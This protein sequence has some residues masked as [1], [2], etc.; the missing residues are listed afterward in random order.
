[1]NNVHILPPEVI[2]KI[3]AGEVIERP[4]AAVKELIENA[5]DAETNQIELHLKQAG[6]TSIRLK[7][8]GT[9]IELDD[10]ENI[11]LRHATSK[12]SKIDDLFAINSL[13]FRGEALYSIATISDV[14]L[15]SKTKHSD[16]GW[17]IHLREGKKLNL[18]PVNMTAGTEIEINEL[19]FNTPAR[20]K[21]L[22]ST[23]VELTQILTTFIP[24]AILYP[25]YKFLLTHN[26]R[27][28]LDLSPAENFI[29]RIC[30]ALNLQ[31][32]HLIETQENIPEKNISIRLVLGD[33]NIQ[34]TRKDMQFIF[35]NNRPVHCYNLSFQI[36]QAYRVILPPQVYPF[37][38][39]YITIPA[40]NVDVNVHPAKREVKIKDDYSLSSFLRAQ[41]EKTLLASSGTKQIKE[42]T[43]NYAAPETFPA[44]YKTDDLTEPSKTK[45]Y[46][47][48]DKPGFFPEFEQNLPI[49]TQAGLKAKLTGA[50][51]MGTFMKKYI[52]FETENSLLVIDQHAAQERVTYENLIRQ[53]NSCKIEIQRLIEPS[54]IKLTPQEMVV[55][56]VLKEKMEEIGL[57]TTLWDNE[58]IALHTRPSLIP[59]CEI[60]VRN[61][62]AGEE[63]TRFDRDT[64]ARR[65]CRNSLMTGYEMTIEQAQYLRAQLIKCADPFTCPHGRPVVVEIEEKIL[66]KQFL[67]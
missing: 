66:N 65:A 4:A 14:V 64:L 17:E 67:R 26:H 48:S 20:K 38:A 5:L 46:I 39:V 59:N 28:L 16:T 2:S 54:I 56:E 3:A 44:A 31:K 30:G 37:F 24:Y 27:V 43:V 10:L 55:W 19:F 35:I 21:F 50:R 12:I 6:K 32:N 34:R 52:F 53:I 62:L 57:T 15:R 36:N 13:G 58:N 41:S 1:M 40:E 51:F 9:G 45:Q 29:A 60:A 7:D 63:R 11:F 8:T 25:Q 22:K 23:A 61:L 47:L 18:R 42:F 49:K 33:M